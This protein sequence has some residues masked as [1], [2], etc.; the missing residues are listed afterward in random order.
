MDLSGRV[1]LQYMS[2]SFGAGDGPHQT[3]PQNPM[4]HDRTTSGGR[5]CRGFVSLPVRLQHISLCVE[6]EGG[7][8]LNQAQPQELGL[9]VGQVG[10]GCITC[11]HMQ[12]LIP[13][14]GQ[15]GLDCTTPWHMESS[16]LG[17]RHCQAGLI[18]LLACMS[19]RAGSR[20]GGRT[21]RIPLLVHISH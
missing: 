5:F 1:P 2:V 7:D 19:S 21:W 13:G 10:P 18:H 16:G 6:V 15:A 20:P 3:G 11:C 4:M 12:E 8:G 17:G 14:T 9:G